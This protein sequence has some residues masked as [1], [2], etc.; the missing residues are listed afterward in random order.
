MTKSSKGTSI[1][2]SKELIT[3]KAYHALKTA[4][5]FRVL[6]L[7]YTKRQFEKSG[8]KGKE[9]YAI[10]NNGEI[11]FSYLEAEKKWKIPS[12]TFARAIDELCDKGFIDIAESGQ[13]VHKV[14]NLYAISN[15]WKN[16]GTDT[17][18]P[19]RERK[20]GP[21]NRGFQKGNQ[22]GRKAKKKSL[23]VT[24]EHGPTVIDEH[25]KQSA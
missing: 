14:C 17:Y 2:F 12:S 8:R 1:W 18:E 22:F 11:T 23:T 9:S 13:G 5:A 7:F 16:Y 25:K 20:K 3:S 15:R 10:K 24:A 19:P 6:S 4:T 21:I